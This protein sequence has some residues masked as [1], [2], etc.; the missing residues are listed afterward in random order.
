MGTTRL[1]EDGR[2]T[3]VAFSADGKTLLSLSDGKRLASAA[4]DATVLVWHVGRLG[5]E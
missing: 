2:V 3:P 4:A 1:R 5:K